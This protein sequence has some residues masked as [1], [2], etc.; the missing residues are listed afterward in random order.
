MFHELLYTVINDP[1]Q[2]TEF[3]SILLCSTKG[4]ITFV[5]HNKIYDYMTDYCHLFPRLRC[6][7]RT[8]NYLQLQL[9]PQFLLR[10]KRTTD[11][12]HLKL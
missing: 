6:F 9:L 12:D 5:F 10:S 8:L 11:L 3:D 1:I 4:L 7:S 2:Y